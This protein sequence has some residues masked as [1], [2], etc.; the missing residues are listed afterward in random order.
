MLFRSD[1]T[2]GKDAWVKSHDI[3]T[4]LP[5]MERTGGEVNITKVGAALTFPAQIKTLLTQWRVSP[6]A[7]IN[8]NDY[9]V[10]Q[11]TADGKIPVN[12]YFNDETG[13]LERV[14]SF[15]DSA[16]G[17]AATQI[18]YSDYRDVAGIKVPH[19]MILTWLDNKAILEL[20]EVQP[21]AKI[22][23]KVFARPEK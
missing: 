8:D 5:L 2:D 15:A 9:T 7:T 10:V 18:D 23:P 3:L 11:G 6:P 22:D 1:V 21:N 12:L 19:K 13:L 20:T 14:V 4:P 16:I 17:Y